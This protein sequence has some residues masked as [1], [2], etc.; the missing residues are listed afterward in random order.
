MTDAGAP[1]QD[2]HVPVTAAGPMPPPEIA[3]GVDPDAPQDTTPEPG[4]GR[5]L[6]F[7][8]PATQTVMHVGEWEP[9]QVRHVEGWLAGRLLRHPHFTEVDAPTAGTPTAGDE[10]ACGPEAPEP[11]RARPVRVR[12]AA[13]TAGTD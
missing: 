1:A 10:P 3:P 12:K 2:V 7:G 9:G 13:G 6:L 5:W 11:E 8:G 4:R